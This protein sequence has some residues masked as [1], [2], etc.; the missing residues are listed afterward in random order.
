MNRCGVGDL[1][2]V[3]GMDC[4]EQGWMKQTFNELGRRE[5]VCAEFLSCVEL[6]HIESTFLEQS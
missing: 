5:R 1:S 2:L 6:S 3:V 4:P